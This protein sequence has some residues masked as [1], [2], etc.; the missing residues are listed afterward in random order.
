[1]KFARHALAI[2]EKRVDFEPTVWQPRT[3][4]D[5]K[6]VWFCGVHADIGGSYPPDKNGQS[7]ADIALGWMMDQ[8]VSADLTLEPHLKAGL[9]DDKGARLHESRRKLFRFKSSLHRPIEREGISMRIHPSVR[10]RYE[11]D[12]S[13]RPPELEKLVNSKGWSQMNVGT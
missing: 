10:T 13:Y 9:S 3:G 2:D 5:L 8:A 12:A 4:V 11:S 7:I 1:V 6:Q